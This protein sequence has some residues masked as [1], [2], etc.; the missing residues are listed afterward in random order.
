M[1]FSKKINI[2]HAIIVAIEVCPVSRFKGLND[3]TFRNPFGSFKRVITHLY[4]YYYCYYYDWSKT[5][6]HHRDQNMHKRKIIIMN[7]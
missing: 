6:S 5:V 2:S 4:Y 1:L 7:V 3:M